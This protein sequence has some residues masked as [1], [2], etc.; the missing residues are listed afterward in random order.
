MYLQAVEIS[1]FKTFPDKTVLTA[2]NGITA[3]VGPNGS[4]KSNIGDAI[5]WVL[6]EQNPRVLR[7]EK[8]MEEVI[9]HGTAGRGP[10]HFAEVTLILRDDAEEK[11]EKEL[12]LTRRLFRSGESEY[13]I[14]KNAVRL[15][16]IAE[17]LMDTGLGHDGYSIIGQ[18]RIGK[19]LSDK[20]GD[21][22][23]VFEEACGISK[24]RH[25]KEEA[26]R[27]LSAA[28]ENL[29]RIGDKIS[30]LELQVEPLRRQ[31]ETA[32]KY[33]LLRD[34]L[35]ALEI[36]VW[37]EQLDKLRR[38]AETV[39]AE[40]GEVCAKLAE[41]G[42]RLAEL[43]ALSE[44]LSEENAALAQ[45]AEKERE[46]LRQLESQAAQKE[47]DIKVL[48][49][50]R[51]GLE[52]SA[53]RTREE[54]A[55]FDE[56]D[57]ALLEQL[58]QRRLQLQSAEDALAENRKKMDALLAELTELGR[59]TDD[60]NGQIALLQAHEEDAKN[61][62]ADALRET[63]A[64]EAA[65]GELLAQREA[66]LGE[67][68]DAEGVRDAAALALEDTQTALAQARQ[69]AEELQN[70]V[71]GLALRK[72]TRQQKAEALRERHRKETMTLGAQTQRR[73]LLLEMEREHEGFSHAVKVVLSPGAGLFGL[74][75][76]VA[77]LMTA[78]GEHAV[79]LE[80]AL[81]AALQNIVV[82]SEEDARAAI[83]LLKRKDAG[84][85]TFLPLSSVRGRRLEEKGLEDEP[86]FVGLGCDLLR[87][88]EQYGEIFASLLGRTA[89]V[90]DMDT[91]IALARR[92]SYRFRIV[93]LDGQV[94]NAG[95][96]ITGGS[97]SRQTGILSRKNELAALADQIAA[98]QKSVSAL[99][100][101]LETAER[102]LSGVT[103][104][105]EVAADERHVAEANAAALHS[106]AERRAEQLAAQTAALEAMAARLGALELRLAED[107]G[108]IETGKIRLRENEEAARTLRAEREA[109]LASHTGLHAQN[110]AAA[111]ALAALREENAA[112]QGRY[113]ADVKSVDDFARLREERSGDRAAKA[114]SV[115]AFEAQYKELSE[116]ILV[117]NEALA[118]LR[119]QCME[120]EQAL[121]ALY[122]GQ[123]EL[124]GRRVRCDKDTREQNESH[125]R[126]ERDRARLENQRTAADNEEKQILDRLWETYG[127]TH[128]AACA[129]R[130]D[131][132]GVTRPA[133]RIAELKKEI[134]DLGTVN[135]GAIEEFERVNT[136]Y[137]YLT[138]QR[139]DA[140]SAKK[141]LE[142]IIGDI[143]EAMRGLFAKQFEQ[144][145]EHFERTFLEIFGGGQAVL[146]L[147][148]PDDILNCDIEIRAQ[149]PGKKMRAISLLSG[150]EMSL[151]AIALYFAIFK[152]RPAPFCVLDEIDH[153]LDDVNVAR[154]ARYL[155]KLAAAAQFLVITHRRGTMEVADMLYGVTAQEEGVSKILALRPADVERA[156]GLKAT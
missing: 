49:T 104:D 148:D 143:V 1:G 86:G 62:A 72:N 80:T 125:N 43:Y 59:S 115:R 114:A 88:E 24:Y 16:D 64:L 146:V 124:E 131:L 105:M 132:S 102:E 134:Q 22:R 119:A 23:R 127:L 100:Q 152:V 129:Q 76:T 9:F 71:S 13:Y 65:S 116:Q 117:Q 21:R 53:A 18:G 89:V 154:F 34:E 20:S 33:L 32:K 5:R 118:A 137:E 4:G 36:T 85:A 30:E 99:A 27:K 110:S 109:L 78:D 15:K 31:S 45:R 46:M 38:D 57:G 28:D 136:R 73:D 145:N 91:G 111:D 2:E 97:L 25:R 94:L 14:N 92:R 17:L 135:V 51:G 122:A 84:R 48:E 74:H 128:S 147:E 140:D 8:R 82:G 103:F 150:G 39:R 55:L 101:E 95:G 151:V 44:T 139:D 133:R 79:A 112:L 83:Q 107:G 77:D 90:T 69:Q 93:T 35:R 61:R 40:H 121:T 54:L 81:G 56:R 3:V 120:Q 155:K 144:I 29:L 47:S 96:A 141:E 75:G 50:Q 26:E 6:G 19:I 106:D 153:D 63:G 66:L 68:R 142:G 37:L 149:P 58:A 7:C 41:S 130:L 70:V 11:D 87:A 156:T 98:L 123:Q 52:E 108:K 126:Y 60:V 12:R 138:A 10:L 113:D 42:A 67:Q